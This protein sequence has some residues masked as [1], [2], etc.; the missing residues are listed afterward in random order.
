[1]RIDGQA[2]ALSELAKVKGGITYNSEPDHHEAEQ[3]HHQIAKSVSF[4]A[5]REAFESFAPSQ[6]VLTF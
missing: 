1:M 3:E 2:M 5:I 6:S 4:A